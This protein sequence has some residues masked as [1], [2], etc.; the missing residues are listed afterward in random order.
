MNGRVVAKARIVVARPARDW[1]ARIAALLLLSWALAGLFMGG[2]DPLPNAVP[3]LVVL[4]GGV[5]G[6]RIDVACRLYSQGHGRQGVILTGG[7]ASRIAADRAALAGRCHVP[8]ASLYHW[9]T[10]RNTFQ[11]VLALATMLA[12][13]PGAHAIV[14]SDSLHMPRLRYVRDRLALNGRVYLRQS[15]LSGRSDTSYLIRV[16]VFW[17]REP[18]AYV[19]YMLRY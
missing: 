18:L 9:P 13:H 14:V 8:D 6:E 5:A 2:E 4:G 19:Y 16:V 1:S 10:T 3:W 17:F 11:E 12:D 7:N 15:R